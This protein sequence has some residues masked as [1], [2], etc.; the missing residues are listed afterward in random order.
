M[1]KSVFFF[2]SCVVITFEALRHRDD[3]PGIFL[4]RAPYA[5]SYLRSKGTI[6][7]PRNISNGSLYSYLRSKGTIEELK[8]IPNGS[9]FVSTSFNTKYLIIT[10]RGFITI[11]RGY[12]VE[13][14][15]SQINKPQQS[16]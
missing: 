16:S 5:I 7:V 8:G 13:D 1:V 9:L 4:I 14:S 3:E 2:P 10:T 12:G 15:A 6:A 11:E